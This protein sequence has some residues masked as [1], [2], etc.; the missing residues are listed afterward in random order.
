MGGW[1]SPKGT[2][3]HEKVYII[4]ISTPLTSIFRV[5]AFLFDLGHT[6]KIELDQE[7]VFVNIARMFTFFIT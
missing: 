4:T 6:I 2:L 7:S 3:Y 5:K 1:I